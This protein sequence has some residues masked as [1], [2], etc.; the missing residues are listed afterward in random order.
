M[1]AAM[2]CMNDSRF[3]VEYDYSYKGNF[4]KYNSYT[5]VDNMPKPSS[6]RWTYM[7]TARPKRDLTYWYPTRYF[8]MI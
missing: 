2:G 5:F 4:K 8:M 7:D 6:T 3:L 1:M